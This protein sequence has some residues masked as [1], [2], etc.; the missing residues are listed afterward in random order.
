[1]IFLYPKNSEFPSL[2]VTFESISF[3]NKQQNGEYDANHKNYEQNGHKID[4]NRNHPVCLASGNKWTVFHIYPVINSSFQNFYHV[5]I[6]NGLK[7]GMFWK[8]PSISHCWNFKST[9]KVYLK[10]L[11]IWH[12]IWKHTIRLFTM[13]SPKVVC[14]IQ[15]TRH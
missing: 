8:N 1:M 13:I 6:K 7:Y 14:K 5:F 12:I 2:D 10:K 9:F 15:S 4:V 3:Q 11:T